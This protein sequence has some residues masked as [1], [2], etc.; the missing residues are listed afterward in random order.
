MLREF[1]LPVL[2]LSCAA[3]AGVGCL[4]TLVALYQTYQAL[5]GRL[6]SERWLLEQCRDPAFFSNMH[7]HSDL[8]I[9]VENHA[10]I[11]ALMLALRE[12]TQRFLL[13]HPLGSV[14]SLQGLISWPVIALFCLALMLG[15]S[16]VLGGCR[17]IRTRWPVCR[18]GHYKNA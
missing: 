2:T 15:P 1:L 9:T 17:T 18:D 8:C 11:G 7:A 6:E 13:H 4:D 5:A 16:G 14:A 3:V 12:H 10:R